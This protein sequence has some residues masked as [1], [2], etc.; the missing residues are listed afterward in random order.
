VAWVAFYLGGTV[1]G[2][3]V[4]VLI[5]FSRKHVDQSGAALWLILLGAVVGLCGVV[6]LCIPP[7][8]HYLCDWMG[9]YVT[10]L[11]LWYFQ[12][13]FGLACF[14]AFVITRDSAQGKHFSALGKLLLEEEHI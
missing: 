14:L 7:L 12:S 10:G 3:S 11:D 9:G 6:C 4:Y 1:F 13:D 5:G 8:Q 2:V